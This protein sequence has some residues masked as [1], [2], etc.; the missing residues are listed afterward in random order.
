[1]TNLHRHDHVAVSEKFIDAYA[2]QSHDRVGHHGLD[3][4]DEF[5]CGV[6]VHLF[7]S[8]VVSRF[9]VQFTHGP[10]DPEAGIP[11]DSHL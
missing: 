3:G 1:M 9:D 8:A 2:R 4:G 6:Q 7:R 10:S 5:S 11:V